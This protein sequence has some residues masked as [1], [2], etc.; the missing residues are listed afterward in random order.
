MSIKLTA[1]LGNS[2]K[3]RSSLPVKAIMEYLVTIGLEIHVQ[4]GTK[5]KMFCRCSASVFGEP[6]NTHTCPVCLGLPGALPVPNAEAIKLTLL[7]GDVLGSDHQEVTR[8]DRKNYFYPDLP[9]GYQIS[10][11]DL[12]LNTGGSIQVGDREIKITRAH[13]EEDTGRLQHQANKTLVDYNRS[14]LPLLEIV[15]EPHIAS[16]EEARSYA[17]KIQQLMRYAGVSEADMEKG[18]LRV[19]AN[20]SIRPAGQEELNPKVEIKNMNSFRSIERA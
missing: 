11:F 12:P 9:K 4:V 13:L 5:S 6:P 3:R 20:V 14:S 19:D 16:A 18:S 1:V 17:Q 2:G 8:F 15:S 7:A 10:Q